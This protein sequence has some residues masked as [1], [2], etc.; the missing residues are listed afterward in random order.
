[1][2]IKPEVVPQSTQVYQAAEAKVLRNTFDLAI[3]KLIQR[4]S[5][6]Q[7]LPDTVQHV[8]Q[9]VPQIDPVLFL[10]ANPDERSCYW[11]NR[12]GS[13]SISGLGEALRLSAE[14]DTEFA[15]LFEQLAS[16]LN[17]IQSVP[18][19]DHVP[20]QFVGG[21]SYNGRSGEQQW[22]DFPA[23]LFVLPEIA[24]IKRHGSLHLSACI[25]PQNEAEWSAKQ[26]QLIDRLRALNFDSEQAQETPAKIRSIRK[27]IHYQQWQ[28]WIDKT[29]SA[30]QAQ[31]FDKAVLARSVSIDLDAPLNIYDLIQR[32]QA[33]NNNAFSFIIRSKNSTFMGCSPERL[34]KR[35]GRALSTESLAGTVRRGET[36][37]EDFHFEQEL[38]SDPKLVREHSLVTEYLK[39]QICKFG[40]QFVCPEEPSVFKLA[41][42]QHRYLPLKVRLHPE[43]SDLQLVNALHPT[44]AICGFPRNA[45][46]DYIQQHETT[47][48]GWYSGIVG[49]FGQD[50]VEFSVAIRSTLIQENQVECFSGVGIVQGATADS[51]WQEMD[52]K[53]ASFLKAL[54]A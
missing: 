43:V 29:L 38:K 46:F 25:H 41:N 14:T 22:R 40:D 3:Q 33:I 32:W 4:I 51:E 54:K 28:Q 21:I 2:S 53:I 31:Q 26:Q 49:V 42:V 27:G 7:Y 11:R 35:K 34:Y 9:P 6:L 23:A 17:G 13:F 5:R 48:R 1:M 37:D 20:I 15:Q 19:E 12:Q 30:I 44:P 36:R 52:A 39:T 8:C 45:A 47:N 16:Y 18:H 50:Y 24:L 10:R